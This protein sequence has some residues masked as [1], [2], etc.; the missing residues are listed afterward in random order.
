MDFTTTSW[1]TFLVNRFNLY[2]FLLCLFCGL[3]LLLQGQWLLHQGQIRE[4]KLSVYGGWF[5]LGL[6][7]GLYLG[8]RLLKMIF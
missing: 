5:Y 7:P 6:G 4:A 8:L 2:F 3:A 1:F